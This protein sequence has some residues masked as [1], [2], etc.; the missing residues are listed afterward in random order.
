MRARLWTLLIVAA[1][2]S[3]VGAARADSLQEE[4][5]EA[6]RLAGEALSKM[7]RAL[8]LLIDSVPHYAAPEILPNG[9]IIIRRLDPDEEEDEPIETDGG[10]DSTGGVET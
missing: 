7:M 8:D 6:E 10:P 5:E 1:L 3:P 9:D 2:A 4:R